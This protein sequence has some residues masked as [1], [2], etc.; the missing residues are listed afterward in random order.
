MKKH[1][2]IAGP[3][4]SK[5][6]LDFNK[7][8][9][10]LL[11]PYFNVYLPQEDGDLLA[12]KEKSGEDS[13]IAR[14]RIFTQDLKAI[15]DCDYIL[16]I[17]DGRTIDEGACFELGYAF[18]LNKTCV[19]FQSDPRRLLFSGNNPMIDGALENIFTTFDQLTKWANSISEPIHLMNGQGL[20]K[21]M[22]S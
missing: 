7:K 5:A 10:S 15:D 18:A 3:L 17:L 22:G 8:I 2:Y 19:G 16:T 13:K 4:F 12:E 11:L 9:K 6:E 21:A 14:R 20:S 1:I